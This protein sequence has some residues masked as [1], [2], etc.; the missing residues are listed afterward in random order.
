VLV[1]NDWYPALD[2][3]HVAVEGSGIGRVVEEG[4]IT[5]DGRLVEADVLLLGTGFHSTEFL[6]P[7]QITGRGGQ[8]LNEAW[9][10]GAEAYL[11]MTVPDFPNL[12][13]LY[14]PNTNL[15][16]N[17]IIV[18]IEAQ[19]EYLVQAV[20]HLRRR[21]RAD[22]DVLPEVAD[23]YNRAIQDE[24]R[25]SVWNAGCDSWYRTASGKVTNNWPGAAYRYRLAA[26]RFEPSH[27]RQTHRGPVGDRPAVPA[28]A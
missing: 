1:S 11:G 2:R 13:L 4:I 15:G 6:A 16:H 24:I 9:A 14:G 12:F 25:D 8:D 17:S 10:D 3:D 18:M 7:M 5:E 27:Y 20:D 23:A 19:V 22:V 26:R 28:P 21:P